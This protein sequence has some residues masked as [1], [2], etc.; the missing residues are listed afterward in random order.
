MC[1]WSTHTHRLLKCNTMNQRLM[2]WLPRKTSNNLF[3]MQHRYE[4]QMHFNEI[5]CRSNNSWAA[6][7][8]LLTLFSNRL[9]IFVFNWK[10]LI[11]LI[12]ILKK[13]TYW[14]KRWQH[15][16]RTWHCWVQKWSRVLLRRS[17]SQSTP[18]AEKPTSRFRNELDRNRA[19]V[20]SRTRTRLQLQV[21]TEPQ[22]WMNHCIFV[23]LLF[24]F[25]K[26]QC[27]FYLIFRYFFNLFII[28]S[29]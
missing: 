25:S 23:S 13:V 17:E 11:R 4:P 22:I 3:S 28:F 19:S 7:K 5:M 10:I 6:F 20:Y 18:I 8:R 29:L 16:Q 1:V 2:L 9:C 27:L 15:D 26:S 24:H 14:C 21:L 12:I